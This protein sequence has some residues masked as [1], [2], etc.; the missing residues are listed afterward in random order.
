MIPDRPF[1]QSGAFYA[2]RVSTRIDWI[3]SVLEQIAALQDA[4]ILQSAPNPSG[5]FADQP[6]ATVDPGNRLI[7]VSQPDTSQYYRLRGCHP[8]R[9]A[10]IEL[11]DDTL[12]FH[13]ELSEP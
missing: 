13:Y 11:L 9:I 10:A 4:P 3:Q 1:D 8:F 5:P 7:T 6:T 12:R 2:T